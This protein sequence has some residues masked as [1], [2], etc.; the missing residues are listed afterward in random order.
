MLAINYKSIQLLMKM[1]STKRNERLIHTQHPT[2][3]RSKML[4]FIIIVGTIYE[5]F[6]PLLYAISTNRHTKIPLFF[7]SLPVE[8]CQGLNSVERI[9]SLHLITVDKTLLATII[10]HVVVECSD[11]LIAVQHSPH[12][13][14]WFSEF[15]WAFYQYTY[16][17]Y[18]KQ[19]PFE[20]SR[21]EYLKKKSN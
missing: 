20:S 12:S 11:Y 14:P 17:I 21:V 9:D 7:L 10:V 8:S 2:L 16:A 19:S 3:D 6:C 5:S 13:R 15:M 1:A 18:D 4:L